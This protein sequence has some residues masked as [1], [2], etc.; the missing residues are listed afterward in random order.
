MAGIYVHIPFCHAKCA[1]CDF[2]SRAG[3]ALADGF[4]GA[5]AREFDTRQHELASLSVDTIYLG[6]GTPSIL[7]PAQFSRLTE[8]FS[9]FSPSEFTIET[10]PEDID[11]PHLEAWQ[12]AGVNRISMGIQSL[13]DSE[14]RAVGRR[15]TARQ[16]VEA[17]H[18]IRR[19]GFTNLSLDLIYGLPGQTLASW[20]YSLDSLLAL[21]PEHLSAYCLTI[22]PRTVLGMK[23]SRGEITE[24]SDEDI[25]LRYDALC[26]TARGLGYDHYEISNFA[27]PAYRSRHN[28]AY[29]NSIPY[30]GLGPG[31]HSLGADGCRRYVESDI[32]RYITDPA[33]C[34]RIDPE[35]GIEK[36]NDIIFTALRTSHGLDINDIPLKYRPKVEKEALR[37]VR[38][39][40]LAC[41]SSVYHI[42]EKDWLTSDAVIRDLLL[43]D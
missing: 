2:Y 22:E 24:A 26:H 42:E 34:L 39:G 20:Q 25:A 7:S 19:A 41:K 21:R 13:V 6:G 27:M 10:N 40:R 28:S 9:N 8:I 32:R 37:L 14:L 3:A 30:L 31:A 35:T 15:H 29:W 17:V 12:Q 16:A 11:Q 18:S 23:L 36:V 5:L 38:Q 33:A 43:C 4:I 1:Y